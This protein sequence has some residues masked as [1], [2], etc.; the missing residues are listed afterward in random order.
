MRN[1]H[2][3]EKVRQLIDWSKQYHLPGSGGIAVFDILE[4]IYY[5][6]K[7]D[8][9]ITRSNS[10]AFSLFLS[11]FPFI[12]FLF[13]LLPYLPFTADYTEMISAS[14]AR[15]L[16]KSAH[17]YL[18]SIIVDIALIRREGLL[19]L[20][21]FFALF[22]SSDGLL[23]LMQGFDKTYKFSFKNRS[24]FH[25]RGIALMLTL[26]LGV[27]LVLTIILLIMGEDFFGLLSDVVH[28]DRISLLLYAI[29]RWLMAFIILYVGINVIYY[30]G[31]SLRKRLPFINPGSIV[32]SILSLLN[33]FIFA[34]F[35]NSFGTYNKIYGSIGALI[36]VLL[37]LKI[38]AFILL[39]GFELNAAIAVKRDLKHAGDQVNVN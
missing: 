4:F 34:F 9:I 36:V 38:N 17:D 8:S 1:W 18:M 31:P 22:F 35:V 15:L 39:A 7:K 33:S 28:N 19:S 12:I 24:I 37:W 6:T 27:L 11:I 13:T 30:F 25:K 32:A 14:T 21:F 29:M 5:E 2:K 10:I 26:L 16:P 20:G 23:T 3:H